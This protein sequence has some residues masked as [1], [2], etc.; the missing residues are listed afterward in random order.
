MQVGWDPEILDGV[1]PVTQEVIGAAQAADI[2]DPTGQPARIDIE[3]TQVDLTA[4]RIR[5]EGLVTLAA[6][7]LTGGATAGVDWGMANAS[8]GTTNGSLLISNIFPQSFTRLR[9]DLFAWSANWYLLQ[10]N[11]AVTNN[12][13]FHLLVVD[14]ISTGEF[15]SDGRAIWLLRGRNSVDVEDPL[16][17][18]NQALFETPNLTIN[19]AVHLTQNASVVQRDQCARIEIPCDQHEWRVDG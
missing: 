14:Q 7:N 17:I 1:F 6:T 12:L 3:G 18:I 16:T 5:A 8:L 10:T 13:N 11:A 2:P 19:S 15:Q 4:A 9:G